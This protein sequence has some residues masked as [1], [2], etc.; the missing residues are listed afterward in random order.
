MAKIGNN[1]EMP[2]LKRFAPAYFATLKV[3]LAKRIS[4]FEQVSRL[5][6]AAERDCG[7]RSAIC[8]IVGLASSNVK[9]LFRQG[10]LAV[11]VEV[12]GHTWPSG[13]RLTSA[14]ADGVI[15][16]S[17]NRIAILSHHAQ[18]ART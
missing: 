14:D 18:V 5:T 8:L 1:A 6:Q 9:K 10:V 15:P 11:N 4:G 16:L 7:V 17:D 2:T 12:A 3:W 13:V